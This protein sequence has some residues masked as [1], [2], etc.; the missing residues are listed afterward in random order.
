MQ[1]E[2]IERQRV[3]ENLIAMQNQIIVQ[4]KLASLGSL[5][6]GIAHEIR[7]PLNFVNNFAEL[8]VD[9]TQ[10][11]IEEIESQTD[12]LRVE[13]RK[14]IVE[15]LTDL[16]RNVSKINEHG[17]RAAR[18]VSN[19]LL[20]A[21][22]EKDEWLTTDINSLLSEAVNLAYHGMRGNDP[23]FNVTLETH[24]DTSLKPIEV[25]Q[26]DINRALI[27]ILSNACY[28]VNEKKK[29]KGDAFSPIL[30]IRTKNLGDQIEICIQ[31]N[32]K[33]MAEDIVAKIF[34][35]FFTTKPTGEGTGLGLSIAHD[36]IVQQHR[37]KLKVE[38]QLE[39]YTK[40]IIFLPQKTS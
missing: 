4:E 1:S 15:I 24:Y 29:E 21:R 37:G 38:T 5:T 19:M 23:R 7:N 25:V 12:S 18:I 30:N 9:L 10:E 11:L 17:R 39:K 32:G 34:N 31:D 40:F 20:Y 13:T 33:G 8:S 6:A 26:E 14:Y 2:I 27:N 35:P 28:V 36:I 16:Q 22:G 3:E